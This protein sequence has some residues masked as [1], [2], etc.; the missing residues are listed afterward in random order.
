VTTP[1]AILQAAGRLAAFIAEG[2]H[3]TMDWMAETLMRRG[4]PRALWPEARSIIM[5]AMNYGPSENP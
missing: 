4:D 1:D 2:Q 5:L 3:G